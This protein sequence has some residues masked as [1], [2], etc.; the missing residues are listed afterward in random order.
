MDN[1]VMNTYAR[2]DLTFV[3]GHGPWVTDV[4]G[5]E[6]LDFVSGIAVNCLGH[7]A[8]QIQKTL[9]EQSAKLIHVS[10][11][12]WSEPQIELAERLCAATGFDRVL[13]QNSGTE[14][15]EAALKMARKYGKEKGGETKTKILCMKDSFHG[16]SM[17]ALSV[18]GQEKYRAPFRPLIGDVIDVEYN[19]LASVEAAMDD[20]VCGV[21]LEPVQGESGIL[22]ATPEF[23]EGVR[24]LCDRHDAVLIFD[25]VQCGMGR[26]G[27]LF[28]FQTYGVEPDV[29][30]T[31]KALAA[32]LPIGAVIAKD[33][34][35]QYFIP[36][37]HG[38]TFGGNPLVCACGNTVMKELTE[39]G[40]LENVRAMSTHLFAKLN[41]LCESYDSIR[42]VRGKGLLVGVMMQPGRKADVIQKAI[43]HGLL[44]ASAGNEVIRFLPPLNVTEA[45][46]DEAVSRFEAALK[47]VDA[48]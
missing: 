26:S 3:S 43:E 30:T 38:C 2:Y 10:N 8:P 1:K 24:A 14:A 18:T 44:L 47:E 20:S 34:V 25:E 36:G 7:A 28:A 31:A 5:K 13:F 29:I 17:G 35:A 16:R 37:D 19:N 33:K 27:E 15:N 21:I 32:G 4:S 23:L 12:Y 45:E 41:A 48:R 39:N 11:L 22:P 46:I 6:Y 40:L 42:L 9:Q